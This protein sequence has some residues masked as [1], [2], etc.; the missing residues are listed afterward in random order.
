MRKHILALLIITALLAV[1]S[2]AASTHTVA[3]TCQEST[4]TVTGFNFYRGTTTGGPYTLAGTS[5]TCSFTDSASVL[6]DGA[7]FFYVATALNVTTESVNSN[8]ANVV[9]PVTIP[10][11]PTGLSGVAK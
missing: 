4:T 10:P 6:V 9:I 7:S 5:P 8:Q 1:P 11:A 2:F 3:L